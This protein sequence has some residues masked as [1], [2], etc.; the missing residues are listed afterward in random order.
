MVAILIAAKSPYT[1]TFSSW[2]SQIT[3]GLEQAKSNLRFLQALQKPCEALATADV[4]SLDKVLPEIVD[5]IRLIQ[6]HSS[7]CLKLAAHPQLRGAAAC[8]LD[9]TVRG[10]LE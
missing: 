10:G 7:L 1:R 6:L 8:G 3:D 5:L 2:A 9:P 4:K